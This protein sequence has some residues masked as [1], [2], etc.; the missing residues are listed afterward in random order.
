MEKHIIQR[1]KC[2]NKAI[3]NKFIGGG[4]VIYG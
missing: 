2:G 3:L 4:S 1:R